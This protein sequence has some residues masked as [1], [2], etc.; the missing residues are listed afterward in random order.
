[1]SV[2]QGVQ[3]SSNSGLEAVLEIKGEIA[4]GEAVSVKFALNNRRDEE[5]QVL[6]WYTPFEGLAGKIF[7]VTRDGIAVPY[8]GILAK[9][10]LPEPGNFSTIEPEGSVVTELDLSEGYDFSTPGDYAIEFISPPISQIVTKDI[11]IAS[12]QRE[13]GPVNIPSNKVSVR[14]LDGDSPD[15]PPAPPSPSPSQTDEEEEAKQINYDDCTSN[16]ESV[17][18]GADTSANVKSA[19]VYAHL[20]SMSVSQRQT[21]A[22]YKTWFGAYTSTRYTKVLSNWKKIMQ[23]FSETITYNCSGP[24]CQSNWYAYVYSGGKLEVF[25][26]NQY[27]G[28]S[29]TGTNTKYGILIH[30]VSHEAASTDDHAYGQTNCQNLAT[31]DPNKAIENAD[32]YEFY[33]EQ[34]ELVIRDGGSPHLKLIAA[35]VLGGLAIEGIRK[36]RGSK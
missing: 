27:W 4:R 28:A 29:D 22:L 9:R 25:L 1:M 20:N 32:N 15:T 23:A 7:Q 31:N 21:D 2:E 30:E 6:D 33:A 12:K 19:F 18:A 17:V 24:A 16:Q 26:C 14:I 5:V 13:L 34:Y 36:L 3:R 10:S 8:H 35:S 11:S